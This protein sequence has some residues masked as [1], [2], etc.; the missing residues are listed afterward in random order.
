MGTYRKIRVIG[1]ILLA[2]GM[3]GTVCSAQSDP[4]LPP[5]AEQALLSTRQKYEQGRPLG[6]D[7]KEMIEKA[8]DKR[9]EAK[10][11]N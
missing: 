2:A 10:A 9:R 11:K 5:G 7:I 8:H 1:V 6:F 4:S 3:S